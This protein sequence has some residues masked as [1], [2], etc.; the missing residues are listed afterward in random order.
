MRM[1]L[2][3]LQ[4][5]CCA[6]CRH[7]AA[8]MQCNALQNLDFV[9]LPGLG[10]MLVHLLLL[11]PA[12]R[13]E[14]HGRNADGAENRAGGVGQWQAD[15]GEGNGQHDGGRRDGGDGYETDCE[16]GF[17]DGS[18]TRGFDDYVVEEGAVGGDHLQCSDNDA[19]RQENEKGDGD[20]EHSQQHHGGEGAEA[21]QLLFEAVLQQMAELPITAITRI[22]PAASCVAQPSAPARNA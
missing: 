19:Y 10:V 4:Q 12:L 6:R 18:E 11:L 5:L 21:A 13:H 22:L 15:A 2:Q 17:E 16:N 1:T 20:E 7:A 9:V 8:A 14:R 3:L